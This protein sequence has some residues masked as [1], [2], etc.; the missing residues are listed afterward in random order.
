MFYK[1]S[2][3][4]SKL[5]HSTFRLSK[6]LISTQALFTYKTFTDT[7]DPCTGTFSY[8]LQILCLLQY[9]SLLYPVASPI[10]IGVEKTYALAFHTNNNS[11]IITNK[12]FEK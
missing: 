2:T 11:K 7:V 5:S 10:L 4:I 1:C 3:S 9:F 6:Y 12:D 8:V